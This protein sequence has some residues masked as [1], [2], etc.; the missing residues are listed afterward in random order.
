MPT[1]PY[2]PA[3]DLAANMK[4]RGYKTEMG[5]DNLDIGGYDGG[6]MEENQ[7]LIPDKITYAETE[8]VKVPISIMGKAPS[9]NF[10]G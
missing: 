4:E 9:R 5:F 10:K 1:R 6:I 7:N 2:H 8:G 3:R